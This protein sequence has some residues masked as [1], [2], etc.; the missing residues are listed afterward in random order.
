MS[1]IVERVLKFIQGIF[2]KIDVKQYQSLINELR[3]KFINKCI[4]TQLKRIPKDK[5]QLNEA[6]TYNIFMSSYYNKCIKE[7]Y[8]WSSQKIRS[9]T[10]SIKRARNDSAIPSDKSKTKQNKKRQKNQ[11]VV[12]TRHLPSFSSWLLNGA[13]TK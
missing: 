5:K 13:L 11:I 3:V 10:Q 4:N 9:M 8:E 7:I 2:I 6:K 1:K 12:R